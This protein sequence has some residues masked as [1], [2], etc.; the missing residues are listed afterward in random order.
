MNLFPPDTILVGLKEGLKTS[1]ALLFYLI[2][3]T[4]EKKKGLFLY[5]II[6]FILSIL[7]AFL[8]FNIIPITSGLL[9]KSMGYSFGIFYLMSIILFYQYAGNDLFGSIIKRHILKDRFILPFIFF[10]T[11]LYF[12]PD[13]TWTVFYLKEKVGLLEGYSP[14]VSFL[15]AAF[16]SFLMGYLLFRTFKNEIGMIFDLPQLFLLLTLLRLIPGGTK[17]ITEFS[18]IPLVKMGMMKLV[19]DVIHQTLITI[20]VPDHMI[21]SATAWNFIGYLFSDRAALYLSLIILSLPIVVVLRLHIT[22]PI[23]LPDD[24]RIKA[25]MR[26]YISSVKNQR[27]WR[28][29]PL[30]IFIFIITVMWFY[31]KEERI[32]RLYNPEAQ[33]VVAEDGEVVIPISSTTGDIRDGMIHKF[34]VN[35][36]SEDIRL[37]IIKG[38]DEGIRVCL[39]ACEICPP[40]GYGQSEGHLVCLYCRT[41][42]PIETVGGSGG[43]HPIPL[44]AVIDDKNIRI[45]ISEIKGKWEMVKTGRTKEIVK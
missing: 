11:L 6:G 29:I 4:N 37:L 16:A 23:H 35:I 15:G 33:P 39:D 24:I 44:N 5:I 14:V 31:Q 36:D 8:L 40:D 2:Y 17:D 22:A 38:V 25:E 27:R 3:L 42:I 21:L 43:C 19:H 13:T 12:I 10:F 1:I 9:T 34:I 30:F 28:S 7:I 18:L 41:P 32:S 20:M 26:K 45:D